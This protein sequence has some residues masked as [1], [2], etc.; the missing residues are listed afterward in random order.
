[1]LGSF[2]KP[3]IHLTNNFSAC[4][5]KTQLNGLRVFANNIFPYVRLLQF[6]SVQAILDTI[7]NSSSIHVIDLEI[8]NGSQW[9][10]LMQSLAVRSPCNWIKLLRITAVGMDADN[11]KESVNRLHDLAQSF[12]I[13]FICRMVQISST[14]DHGEIQSNQH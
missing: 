7:V 11:L 8:R 12:G 6:T 4:Y 5:N 9:S 3:V 10:I 14:E 2:L 1:M 13:S